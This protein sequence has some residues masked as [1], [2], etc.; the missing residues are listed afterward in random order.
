MDTHL[1]EVLLLGTGRRSLSPLQV[2][3][4]IAKRLDEQ[5]S[6]ERQALQ[7]L[8]YAI[9]LDAIGQGLLRMVDPEPKE[10][11]LDERPT[12]QP[13]ISALL[14]E[15]LGLEHHYK[16]RWLKK[17][18]QL[19]DDRK[20]KLPPAAIVKLMAVL[21]GLGNKVQQH[22]SRIL[23]QTTRT[24]F[25][26]YGLWAVNVEGFAE[27]S[28][29][30][31]DFGKPE[32]RQQYWSALHRQEAAAAIALLQ[33]DWEKEGIRDKLIFLKLIAQDL[34]EADRAFLVSLHEI[35][36][37]G[38]RL[39][40]KTAR[41]CKRLIIGLL[42][43]LHHQPLL[44]ELTTH[45]ELYVNAEKEGGLLGTFLGKTQK[46][47]KLPKQAD[48]FWSGTFLQ[49]N[50]GLEPKNEALDRFDYDPYFWLAQFLELLPFA[51]MLQLLDHNPEESITYWLKTPAYNT[52]IR[53]AAVAIFEQTLID[54]AISEKD[55]L[56][57]NALIN[58]L[59]WKAAKTLLP[60]ISGPAFEQ[61]VSKNRLF[62]HTEIFDERGYPSDEPWSLAFSKT[63]TDQW[64]K[65]FEV[66]KYVYQPAVH[67][68]VAYFHPA[69]LDYLL[70]RTALMT[71]R[72]ELT[73]W[74]KYLVEP[75]K[76]NLRIRN[77]IYQ[78]Q[79]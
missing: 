57:I 29:A 63:M 70:D 20:E 27:Y 6:P 4:E 44:S 41:L 75:L 58:V 24:L 32:E 25:E 18:L 62:Q 28:A 55:A 66:K 74:Q 56:L 1:N 47:L 12:T 26:Q 5:L 69:A 34:Q 22:A 10:L 33:K 21:P 17:W 71:K 72:E 30:T 46:K 64:I 15:I 11:V 51:F 65:L 52:R 50:Y 13:E 48:A 35:E 76:T 42:I 49:A 7:A 59:D 79:K 9:Y 2:H 14:D 37:T 67:H 16:L 43:R 36:F 23:G 3:P 78:Y 45:L 68:F 39:S 53:G 38:N 54:K 40:T 73:S 61:Y 8:S 19:V 77:K 60:Y 31:W